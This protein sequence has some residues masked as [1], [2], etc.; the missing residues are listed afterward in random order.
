MKLKYFSWI[1]VALLLFVGVASAQETTG[2]LQGTV[3]DPSGAIV[4]GAKVVITGD[5]L[6]GAK[7]VETD[8]GGYYRFS[9]LPPGTYAITVTAK[10]FNTVKREG[11][12]IEV[13]H[14]P[15]VDI[16]LELGS[17]QTVV[18]VTAAAPLIDT[19]TSRTMTN[20]TEDVIDNVPHGESFQ[21]I[22]QF[23]P[24]ARNEPLQG[25]MG[26]GTPGT[27]GCSPTGC[28]SGA[29]NGYQVAGA[30]DSENGYLVEGQDTA[31]LIGGYSHTNVPF[32]FIQEV[33]V[34]TSG[35]E[36]E[37][38]GALGGV[39]NV[40]MRKGSNSWHGGID[41]QYG[42]SALNGS[43]EDFP[44]YDPSVSPTQTSWGYIDPTYQQYS[45]KKDS[46]K[47]FFPGFTIGGPILKD[48]LWFFA[49]FDPELTKDSRTVDYSSQGL[50]DLNFNQNTQTYYTTARIDYSATSKLRLFG[51]WL[52]QY[53]RLAGEDLPIPDS[54]QGYFNVSSSIP[55]FAYAHGLGYGAPNNTTN[56]GADW[57]ISQRVVS[58]TRFGY[59]FENYSDFGFPTGGTTFL[60]QSNGGAGTFEPCTPQPCT[61]SQALPPDLMQAAGYFNVA[62]NIN[63]TL[64]NANK[65]YQFNQ[66]VAWYKSGWWGTHNFKFGYQLNELSNDIFQRWNQPAVQVFP[67]NSSPYS[68]SGPVGAANCAAFVTAYGSCIGQYGYINVQDYG[69][70]GNATS[71]NHGFFAQDAWSIGHGITINAGL[72]IEHEFL[73]A[74]DQPAGGINHPIDFGWGDKIAPRLGAAWDVFRNGKMKIFGGYGVFNDIMKLNL[75]I[76]SFGGQYWQNCNYALGTSDLSSIVPAFNSA[77]R[78]CVGP[79]S[80]SEANWAGGVTPAG[81]TFLENLNYRAFPTTCPTCTATEEGVAPNLKPYRQHESVIGTDY[82]LAKTLAFEA[83]W[84]RRRLDH[85]IEDS[86]LANP[87]VGETFVIVNPGQGVNKTFDGFYNFLYGTSSGCTAASNPPCKN[88]IA[89]QR[90][91]DGLE[92]RLTKAFSSHWTGMFSYTYSRL[93]GNYSGLTNT[94]F[95]DAGGGRNSPNNSRAFDEPFYSWDSQ[96]E[97]ASGLMPTD[98]PNA[99]KGYTYY[100]LNE[101]KRM[102]TDFGLFAFLY[103]GTA[104]TSEEDVG[105]GLPNQPYDPTLVFGSSKW[106]DVSQDPTTGQVTVSSPYTKRTPWFNQADVNI[107]ENYKFH[108]SMNVRFY[109]DI[110]NVFNRRATTAYWTYINSLY[111]YEYLTPG[112]FN[113]F[114]GAPFYAAAEN[115]YSVQGLMNAGEGGDGVPITVNSRYGKPYLFQV[116]R[117][118]RLGLRWTF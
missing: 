99:F 54:K 88:N 102:S 65:R 45:P 13:G 69:S 104:Q 86:A 68:P 100:T 103:Q 93:W 31:N 49:G 44:R 36:A 94:N 50:G 16:T 2:G 25:G 14:L 101:G 64:F 118:I 63:N 60:F 62:N 42:A 51:S 75:A 17:S 39:V 28:S 15:S 38:G 117:N 70:H 108:E 105:F 8:A 116:S 12:T 78:Y 115:G 27:G 56:V 66:D 29:A 23:A 92:F 35:I 57:T 76:S 37:S 34:K 9:N 20:V 82:Q 21:S 41:I 81:L 113:N 61:P 107:G 22:I 4:P 24:S 10:G 40:I 74:E 80:A 58:S 7:E 48:R 11:M 32:A 46:T 33:Q 111:S 77:G 52:Y 97:S 91:Y 47:D 1:A 109:A 71:R 106:A 96:G 84:D 95:G 98:R 19:T 110:T 73:P 26:V 5:A 114:D 112:G 72:R 18:E 85:A 67:G 43:P 30:A 55:P 79:N 89:A 59:Y 87:T 6:V 90:S 83:R 3:K 53:Q